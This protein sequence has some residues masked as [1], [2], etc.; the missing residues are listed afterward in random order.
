MKDPGDRTGRKDRARELAERR[1]RSH[2]TPV[3][4]QPA[5]SPD[6]TRCERCGLVFWHKTWRR[7]RRRAAQALL[8]GARAGTCP[9][10]RQAQTEQALGRVLLMAELDA[11]QQRELQRRIDNVCRRAAFTQPER[12]LLGVRRVA[13]GLEVLTTSQELAHRV[14]KEVE[15]AF[16]GRVSYDWSDSDGR[17]LARWHPKTAAPGTKVRSSGRRPPP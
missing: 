7:S 10:C 4:R 9:A 11:P 14:A 15:K 2:R 12:R 8:S 13:Q 1:T 5:P 17:L 3:S 6:L 16:G